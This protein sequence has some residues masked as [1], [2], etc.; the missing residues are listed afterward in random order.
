MKKWLYRLLSLVI[1]VTFIVLT[2]YWFEWDLIKTATYTLMG[3]YEWII[4]MFLG[5]GLAFV[6][7][8]YAWKWYLNPAIPLRSYLHALFYSLFAN[9]LFPIKVG[10]LVRIGFIMKEKDVSWDEAVHSVIAMRSMDLIA[11]GLFAGLGAI[12]FDLH[13]SWVW[14]AL[15]L[16][17]LLFI[18]IGIYHLAKRRKLHFF[19][20][21]VQMLQGIRSK[22]KGSI[23]ITSIIGSWLL[24]VTV[25][26]GVVQSLAVPL[27]IIEA[28]WVNSMTI[29]GQVFHF[30]PGGLGT[31]QSTMSFSLASVEVSW[32]DAYV[33]AIISHGFKFL[34]SYIVGGYV[35]LFSPIPWS[36]IKEWIV[37]GKEK[38]KNHA[39]KY[40]KK[41]IED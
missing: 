4:F 13:I 10:D 21:H 16:L 3:H 15:L 41:R 24:E 35:L 34:F 20:K 19:K 2:Y 39:E 31:Y 26:V 33:V 28:I 11:L 1:I 40:T 17:L 7:R 36:E 12:L 25:L 37:K 5:Y 29:A 18:S 27:S 6:L 30:T 8:A 38:V 32:Q 9:H 22:K 14:Y 23:I